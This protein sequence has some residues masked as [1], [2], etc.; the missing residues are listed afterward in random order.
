[1][2]QESAYQAVLGA[3]RR[4]DIPGARLDAALLHVLLAKRALHLLGS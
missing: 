1:V 2:D 3:A 4:G